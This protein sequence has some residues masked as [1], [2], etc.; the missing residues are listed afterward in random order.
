MYTHTHTHTHY[1]DQTTEYSVGPKES[2]LAQDDPSKS[3]NETTRVVLDLPC[4]LTSE[5]S[6][7][8]DIQQE[9]M[10]WIHGIPFIVTQAKGTIE[11]I[12][13]WDFC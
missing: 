6:M 12:C 7:D 13:L 4:R 3:L 9:S 10:S 1:I 5:S 11:N 8:D 2:Q